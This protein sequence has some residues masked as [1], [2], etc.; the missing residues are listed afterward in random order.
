MCMCMCVSCLLTSFHPIL[1]PAPCALCSRPRGAAQVA[2]QTVGHHRL[3][4]HKGA[5][6]PVQ[7]VAAWT[8]VSSSSAKPVLLL[9]LYLSFTQ[10]HVS[11]QAPASLA[12]HPHTACRPVMSHGITSAR[13]NV[14]SRCF[15]SPMH[16]APLMWCVSHTS[17]TPFISHHS[18]GVRCMCLHI[19]RC[20]ELCSPLSTIVLCCLNFPPMPHLTPAA[21]PPSNP[22]TPLSQTPSAAAHGTRCAPWPA[23]CACVTPSLGMCCISCC[24]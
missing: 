14:H 8:Q 21:Q 4:L 19:Q 2:P 3:Q 10:G 11:W 22:G 24:W 12:A 6:G 23:P 13:H 5:V 15:V 20:A 16:V 18:L 9:S 7:A 17:S 1:C